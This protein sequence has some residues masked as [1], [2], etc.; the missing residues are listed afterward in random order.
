[1][2]TRQNPRGART[3]AGREPVER[4]DDPAVRRANLRRVFALFR[5]YRLRLARVLGL[6]LVS[7]VISMISPFLIRDVFIGAPGGDQR[8]QHARR[9]G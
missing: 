8:A 1:M 7:A 5:P 4:P 6:I 3:F 2:R 9:S